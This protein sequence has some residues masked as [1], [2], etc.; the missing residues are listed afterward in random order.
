M[1]KEISRCRICGNSELDSI[2]DLGSQALTGVFPLPGEAVEKAPLE[3]VKCHENGRNSCGLVQLRHSFEPEKM[4]GQNY[5]YRSGLNRAM[6]T[7]LAGLASTAKA[8]VA[9]SP[10]DV[11]LD[12]GSNDST[13]LQF[14]YEPGLTAVGMD[15]TGVK[16]SSLYPPYIQLIPE[17]FS[18]AA[19]FERTGYKRAKIVSSIA[20]FYDLEAPLEFM[21]QVRDV[22]AERGVWIF[23]QSYLPTMMEKNSYDTICH[24]HLE[25]YRLKQIVWMAERVGLKILDVELN[26]A[27]GGSFRI[28]AGHAGTAI[29]PRVE[30]IIDMLSSEEDQGF[31]DRLVYTLFRNRVIRHRDDLRRVLDQLKQ[32][33]KTVLGYGASTKGNVMLQF[34]GFG[35]EDLP[36]IAE[37]N[38]DKFGRVTPGTEIPI[39]SEG[40]A[41]ALHPDA[42]LVLPWHFRDNFI[43]RSQKYLSEGHAFIFPLPII[44]VYRSAEGAGHRI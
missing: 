4:Y 27:N 11:I 30:K 23:E 43:S 8:I 7:H 14:M 35:A 5:G 44:E 41:M 36:C 10:G 34:C 40:E 17:F 19:F 31:A 28:L 20:M 26:E 16:F 3:L 38:A 21:A 2:L 24:E 39:V 33:G 1:Y 18:S 32:E 9:L 6:K 29:K 15:P 37:V 42:L 25:Y 12:I 22:L 13:L